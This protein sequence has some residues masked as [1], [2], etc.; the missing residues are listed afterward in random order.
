MQSIENERQQI[1][2][3]KTITA[4]IRNEDFHVL[5]WGEPQYARDFIK[6]NNAPHVGG[7]L[8]GFVL[9]LIWKNKKFKFKRLN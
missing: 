8:T 6:N 9:M 1:N 3:A 5:R 4:T 7:A 2:L